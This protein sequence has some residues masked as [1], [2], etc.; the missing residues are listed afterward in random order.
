[1][2]APLRPPP[3]RSGVGSGFRPGFTLYLLYFFAFF[4]FFALLLA[5]PALLEGLR[6]LP[7]AES[8]EAE[9]EAGARIAR[10]A[11]AGRL[12]LALLA[13][14]AAIGIGGYARVLPGLRDR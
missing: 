4:V 2:S 11:L 13:A 7:P 9:R 1:M 3:R 5:L 8:I 12:P 10:H 6:S 14:L